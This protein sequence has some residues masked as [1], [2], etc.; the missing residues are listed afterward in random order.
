MA[1]TTKTKLIIIA[2]RL[3]RGGAERFVSNLMVFLDRQLFDIHLCLGHDC[4][5]YPLPSDV[6]TTILYHNNETH[7]AKTVYRL[8]KVLLKT[9][10][11]VILSTIGQ[12]NRWVGLALKFMKNKPKWVARIGNN[13]QSSGRS[14]WRNLINV[15]WD[16]LTYRSTDVFVTNS[17]GLQKGFCS[18]HKAGEGK[19]VSIYN[20]TDFNEIRSKAAEESKSEV[21]NNADKYIIVHAGRFHRQ[22]R[23]DLLLDSFS[24]IDSSKLDKPVELWLCGTGYLEKEIRQQV[25]SSG[26]T[27]SVRFLG[28]VHSPYQ[29]FKKADL[30]ILTSD[31]EGMPNV[32]VEA[33]GLDTPVLSTDCDY[34]PAEL[35]EDGVTGYLCSTG[36]SALIAE[37]VVEALMADD[38]DQITRNA[39]KH[40]NKLFD[41]RVNMKKW[42][43]VLQP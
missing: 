10:P 31:W 1:K 12:A 6:K 15:Q 41:Y 22:K 34:G 4:I 25:M 32:L 13:P 5:E 23:H 20:P 43:E 26:L 40:I 19:T 3:G 24:Q 35:I 7:L 14:A 9:E 2:G 8:R 17:L 29:I 27:D 36:D 21:Y 11:D 38:I 28:H 37:K 39:R 42:Q 18:L 30:F 33:M 16:K